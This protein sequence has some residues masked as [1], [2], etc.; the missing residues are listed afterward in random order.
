MNSTLPPR[1]AGLSDIASQY[2]VVL[3]DV[4]GVVHNGVESGLPRATRSPASGKA[5]AASP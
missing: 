5:A 1:I 3:C 4:W 2:E